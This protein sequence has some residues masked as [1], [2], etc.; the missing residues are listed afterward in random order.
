MYHEHVLL[1]KEERYV[2]C[3]E[4]HTIE[5][6]QTFR[7]V[8]CMLPVMSELLVSTKHISIDTSFKRLHNWQE[9]EVEAWFSKY[10]RCMFISQKYLMFCIDRTHFI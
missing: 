2:W 9:F 3:V 7:L 5:R 8:A 1:L 6:N 4:A 10:N